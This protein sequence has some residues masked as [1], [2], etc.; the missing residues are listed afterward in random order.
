MDLLARDTAKPPT[1]RPDQLEVAATV[2]LLRDGAQG[3]ETFLMRRAIEASVLGG[4]HVFPGG[5]LDAADAR[6]VHRLDRDAEDLHAALGEP[7][8]SAPVA[9]AIHVAALREL[10]EEAGVLL[11]SG[12]NG[13][14]QPSA[15]VTDS[16]F[17]VASLPRDVPFE[18]MLDALGLKLSSS[19]IAPWSRWITPVIPNMPRRR[20]DTRF[21][22]ARM[23]AGQTADVADHESTIGRWLGAREALEM[24]WQRDIELAPPQIITLAHLSR[25]ASADSAFEAAR[26]T[27]PRLIH[28]VH[29][30]VDAER[31]F[32]YPGDAAH[33]D[34]E[35]AFPGVSRLVLREGRFEP[36]DGFEAFFADVA[37]QR[38]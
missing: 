12:P 25:Y 35:R 33:G 4:V 24:Y 31:V 16:S 6:S 37:T 23:P 5:K 13:L 38:L 1:D 29:V 36:F 19:L 21:F 11:A 7:E 30:E 28:P 26:T 9:A 14:W 2:V 15:S 20:F 32:C 18:S 22:V 3:V 17:A 34:R 27:P 10:F 8:L